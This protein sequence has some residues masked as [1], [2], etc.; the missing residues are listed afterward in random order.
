V[1][2]TKTQVNYGFNRLRF[3]APVPVGARIRGRFLLKGF[4]RKPDRWQ[5]IYDVVVEIEGQT[6]PALAAEWIAAG[7]LG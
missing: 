1:Q 7:F 2:G 4:E 6:K 5:A 3:I